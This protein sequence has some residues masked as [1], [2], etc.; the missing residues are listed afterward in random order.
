MQQRLDDEELHKLFC[1]FIKIYIDYFRKITLRKITLRKI[2][3][4][5]ITLRLT[6]KKINIL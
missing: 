4:R 3:L 1:L 5:K 6:F 2:T